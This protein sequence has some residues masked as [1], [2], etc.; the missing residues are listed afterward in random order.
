[1]GGENTLYWPQ[2]G[3]TIGACRA[4]F[5]IDS[6]SPVKAFNLNFGEETTSLS[7][8]LRVK[9]E[10]SADWFDLNGRRLSGKPTAKGLYIHGGKKVAIK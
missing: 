7:E 10:E 5:E 4:Y 2:D 6:S 8:E 1:M 9:S 3:A